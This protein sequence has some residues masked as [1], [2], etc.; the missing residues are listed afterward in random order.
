[1]YTILFRKTHF[2]VCGFGLKF[3]TN[4]FYEVDRHIVSRLLLQVSLKDISLLLLYSCYRS[5]EFIFIVRLFSY[6]VQ[7]TN[8]YLTPIKFEGSGPSNA[9]SMLVSAVN[10]FVPDLDN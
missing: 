7:E 4:Y 1:M 3:S 8:G 10:M 5:Q 6:L 2:N 9:V